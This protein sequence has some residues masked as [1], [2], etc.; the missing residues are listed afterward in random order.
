LSEC[1]RR[2]RESCK[3]PTHLHLGPGLYQIEPER[4]EL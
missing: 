4:V 1:N 2:E 3:K